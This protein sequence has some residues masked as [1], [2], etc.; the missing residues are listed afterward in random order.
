MRNAGSRLNP[1]AAAIDDAQTD[2][3][4]IVKRAFCTVSRNIVPA[5]LF[6]TQ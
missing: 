5:L 6:P 2:I 3:R 1:S 4:E